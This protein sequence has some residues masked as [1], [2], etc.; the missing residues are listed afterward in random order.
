MQMEQT[1]RTNK[2]N[3]VLPDNLTPNSIYYVLRSYKDTKIIDTYMST[4]MPAP[5]G[6][7][8]VANAGH[9]G[10]GTVGMDPVAR[11]ASLETDVLSTNT[12][13]TNL[14]FPIKDNS[15]DRF[16]VSFT[17]KQSVKWPSDSFTNNAFIV[18]MSPTASEDINFDLSQYGYSTPMSIGSINVS[19][20]QDVR[21][22]PLVTMVNVSGTTV[23]PLYHVEGTLPDFKDNINV[24][25]EYYRNDDDTIG[26]NIYK[27]QALVYTTKAS[28]TVPYF[29]NGSL[30]Y[31]LHSVTTPVHE[32]L[33]DL[34]LYRGGLVITAY[35]M[36]D[37]GLPSLV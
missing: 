15:A 8:D 11:I 12:E 27:Q 30:T 31:H 36:S 7:M 23:V 16:A 10:T 21:I 34:W 17:R 35:S 32:R 28:P 29:S 3:E 14:I 9:T 19:F 2:V 18:A 37:G 4:A 26:L 22:T 33:T 24:M 25:I 13:G 5:S 6:L 20:P 1:H